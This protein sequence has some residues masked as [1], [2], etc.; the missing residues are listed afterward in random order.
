[1]DARNLSIAVV[2]PPADRRDLTHVGTQ[3]ERGKPDIFL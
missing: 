3:A 1:M 2:A